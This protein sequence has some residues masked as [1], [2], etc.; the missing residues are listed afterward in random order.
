MHYP[1]NAPAFRFFTLKKAA[2][3]IAAALIVSITAP[4]AQAV[5]GRNRPA[6]HAES[7]DGTS[8][9]GS[10]LA[11]HV[12]RATRDSEAAALYYRRALAKDPANEEILGEAFQLEL[13]SGN[14]PEAKSLAQRLTRRQP[15]NTIAHIFLGAEAYR[16]Q[17]YQTA[18]EHFKAAQRAATADDPTIKL[19]RAWTML[20]MGHA[21]KAIASM[22]SQVK[23]DWA[24]HFE[25]VQRA[26]MA[27][28][29][30][31]MDDAEAAYS[32]IYDKQAPNLRIAEAYARHLAVLGQREKAL[33]LVQETGVHETPMGKVLLA[34]LKAGKTPKLMVSTPSEGLAESYLG[35]G[36]VLSANNGVDAAQIYFRLALM[37]N[38]QSDIAKLE[39]AELY[40]NVERFAKAIAVIDQMPESSPFWVNSQMRKGLYLNSMQKAEEAS[41]LLAT[42]LEKRPDNLQLLQTAAAVESSRKNYAAAIPYYD[43]A[44]KLIGTP[45]KKDWQIYY[46]RGVAFE[47]TKQWTKAEPDFKKS[48]ELDPEQGATLN[49][50]GYSW[51]DQNM[52]IPEAFDLIKKAVRLHPNDGYIIDSLGWAYYLQKDYEQAVKQLDKAVE[53]RPE[54]PTLNDHLG[55]V[56]WRLGRKLEAKFQWNQALSLN[57][58]PE[59]ATKIKKKVEMGLQDEAGPRAELIEKPAPAAAQQP[60]PVP[61][62][63]P[64]PAPAPRVEPSPAPRSEAAPEA[65]PAAVAAPQP[66]PAHVPQ[67]AAAPAPRPEPAPAAEPAPASTPQPETK[68]P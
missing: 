14:Y 30:K 38:P 23:T 5:H 48:L 66:E 31:S 42:M 33:L 8:L 10:Y 25:T 45:Q 44:I 11:G 21:K 60:E 9:L 40:G 22:Q 20:G 29:A 51:L 55:D 32:A 46:S 26:F 16:N 1:K 36:Q 52:N 34:E 12:A 68:T 58:E 27:D 53:L 57:P 56:Y 65:Q 43:Q 37:L 18:D 62:P 63:Q 41:K 28:V 50:L 7:V 24:V 15:D 13:A 3:L 54:D 61:A 6:P 67:P 17:D 2:P 4:A 39:L 47:R 64:E 59:D 49:Y 19:S 35:I